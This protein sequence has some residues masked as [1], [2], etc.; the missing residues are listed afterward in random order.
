MSIE[1]VQA[2]MAEIQARISQLSYQPEPVAPQIDP[3]FTPPSPLEGSPTGVQPFPVAL[4]AQMGQMSVKPLGV[5]G[6]E[7]FKPEIEALI[8]KYSTQNSLDP[9]VVR[10][11]IRAESDG[12]PR[13]VS[14]KGAMGLMQLMPEEL[15]G[16]G[17]TDPFDP[18]QNIMGGTRQL[19]EKLKIFGGDLSLALAAYNAGT[20]RVKQYNG[21]PPFPE[22][23]KYVAKITGMLAS[24]WG[25]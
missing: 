21:I 9:A 23:R 2:R 12:D 13:C 8:T 18:E 6:A 7:T 22:T 25:R 3:N 24:E 16:Y 15:K 1:S 20:S 4:A 14:N 11:V 17:V 19:A 10:A 5:G